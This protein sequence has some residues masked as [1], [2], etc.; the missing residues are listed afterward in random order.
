VRQPPGFADERVAVEQHERRLAEPLEQRLEVRRVG[1][2]EVEVGVA[3]ATVHLHGQRVTRR[4]VRFQRCEHVVRHAIEAAAVGGDRLQRHEA[5]L[6][7]S[8]Y[9]AG[10]VSLDAKHRHRAAAGEL[11]EPFPF[12]P[13]AR[14]WEAV[15]DK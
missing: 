11:A 4:L 12:D 9:V 15:V 1:A 5:G 8:R 14:R 13:G 7:R 2:P 6:T 10:R 3:E